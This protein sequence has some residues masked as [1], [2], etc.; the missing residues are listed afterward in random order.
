MEQ[1]IQQN[2]NPNENNENNPGGNPPKV[3]LT[4]LIVQLTQQTIEKERGR[5]AEELRSDI[6]AKMTKKYEHL[7]QKVSE[8][9]GSHSGS[10]KRDREK[11][12]RSSTLREKAPEPKKSRLET[13]ADSKQDEPEQDG[14]HENHSEEEEDDDKISLM[15]DEENAEL[16]KLLKGD[17]D[18]QD[19][20]N[21]DGDMFELHSDITD[22]LKEAIKQD[23]VSAAIPTKLADLLNKIWSQKVGNIKTVKAIIDK[24]HR[25][26]NCEFFVP[27]RVNKQLY[28][29]LKK[30]ATDQDNR[31][32]KSQKFLTTAAISVADMLQKL[33]SLNPKY[34]EDDPQAVKSTLKNVMKVLDGL[35]QNVTDA[36]TMMSYMNSGMVQYRKDKICRTIDKQLRSIRTIHE[37]ESRELFG[38]DIMT[39]LKNAKKN[40][41]IL[42]GQKNKGY[43][44]NKNSKNWKDSDHNN[45][46]RNR[47]RRGGGSSN[48]NRGGKRGGKKGGFKPRGDQH[49]K[50]YYDED[51]Y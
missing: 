27:P 49:R 43:Y 6:E 8:N 39:K 14:A 51:E 19:E 24:V 20:D 28:T 38:E 46:N 16:L 44:K 23:A 2:P 4:T 11:E 41:A 47:D 34:K 5:I 32:E 31:I 36:F 48:K 30:E 3:P 15:G 29:Y 35:K 12:G 42:G 21:D 13:T 1:T 40:Y 10:G 45:R 22:K 26:E 9:P 33:M 18:Q 25:P 50:D 17:D 7:L 37:P